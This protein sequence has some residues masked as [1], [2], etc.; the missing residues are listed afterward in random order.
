MSNE[1][2]I[3]LFLDS[4]K[5]SYGTN[6][7]PY[8][9]LENY[10]LNEILG[11]KLVKAVFSTSY[12]TINPYNNSILFQEDVGSVVS[13]TITP[14]NYSKAQFETEVKAQLEAESPNTRTYTVSISTTTGKIT[15]TGSTGT[16]EIKSCSA[17]ALLGF[18]NA[19]SQAV[20]QVGSNVVNL[21]GPCC[22][23]LRS[24]AL[25]S[26]MRFGSNIYNQSQN[27]NVLATVPIQ[28]GSFQVQTHQP[29]TRF[30]DVEQQLTVIDYY[31][32]DD[33]GR[34]IGFNGVPTHVTFGLM[35]EKRL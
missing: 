17:L 29:E 16:F 11:L 2:Y 20:T 26:S 1:T 15:I 3:E 28:N 10:T 5:R 34:E 19:T 8:F 23:Q 13:A 24:S 7:H 12:Y 21:A 30:H 6:D 33:E 31:F 27:N 4:N 18:D 32:T 14:G 25:G 35:M 9:V 22:I